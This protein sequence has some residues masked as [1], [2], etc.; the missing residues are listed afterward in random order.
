MRHAPMRATLS[1]RASMYRQARPPKEVSVSDLQEVVARHPHSVDPRF[2]Q[3]VHIPVTEEIQA[4]KDAE[5]LRE[6]SR[7]AELDS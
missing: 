2:L 7:W 6:L 5:Y 3:N 1:D 4:K